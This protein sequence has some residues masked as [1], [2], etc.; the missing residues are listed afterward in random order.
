MTVQELIDKLT[1]LNKPGHY[2]MAVDDDNNSVEPTGLEVIDEQGY[3]NGIW[4]GNEVW[5]TW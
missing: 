2:F 5:F 4:Q 1:A 3:V